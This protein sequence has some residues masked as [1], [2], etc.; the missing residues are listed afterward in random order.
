MICTLK[1]SKNEALVL[2]F[3]G[4]TLKYVAECCWYEQKRIKEDS[5]EKVK[6]LNFLLLLLLLLL[7]FVLHL[8]GWSHDRLALWLKFQAPIHET[9]NLKEMI[10]W[11]THQLKVFLHCTSSQL[12]YLHKTLRILYIFWLN[13]RS[14]LS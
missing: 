1:I 11:V 10:G 8:F 14:L 9:V 5:E 4:I 12:K 3:I 7:H 6:F 2:V 13:E